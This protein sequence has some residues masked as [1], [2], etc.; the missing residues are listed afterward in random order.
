M[1][2]EARD[3][4][5][6]LRASAERVVA[7]LHLPGESTPGSASRTDK[8]RDRVLALPAAQIAEAAREIQAGFGERHGGLAALLRENATKVLAADQLGDDL[9]V[10]L[11][12]AFT[13]E[14]AIEGAALCNPSVVAHPDQSGL[15]PGQLR[16]VV[17]L[18]SIG[19][20]HVSAISFCTA[21]VGPGRTWAFDRRDLPLVPAATS[22][23]EW[24][25]AHL[26]RSLEYEGRMT[27]L[28]R[29]VIQNLPQRFRS[30]DIERVIGRVPDDFLTH[31]D[32]R[33]RTEE[34]RLVGRSAY[35]A[36]FPAE[37]TLSQRVLLPAADEER[38]GM[39]DARFVRFVE[40]DGSVDYRASYTAYDGHAISSRLLVT[41]DFESFSIRRL[42]GAGTATKGM[43]FFPRRIGGKLFCITRSDGES[44]SLARSDDGME[45]GEETFLRAPTQLWEVIQSGNCGSPIETSRGWLLLTHGVGPMRRYSMGAILL[46]LEDPARV[47]AQLDAPLLEPAGKLQDG[48]VPN[49][50]Y[51]C[52]GIVSDG[53]LWIPH[54]VGDQSIRVVSV[55]LDDLIDAMTP[56]PAILGASARG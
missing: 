4:G 54:G 40:D 50:V 44:L 26:Q 21:I 37:S 39:E 18:R 19:E 29:S 3:A 9:A 27:E 32:A 30:S 13:T 47:V 14:F 12:A 51:S 16:L 53:V 10:V 17:S 35:D 28:A 6:E 23:G 7:N 8:V 1:S 46:D 15:A 33:A 41:R 24:E 43:A 34:I 20:G 38:H 45:W 56:E 11:G 42:S 55:V 36:V 5:V 2:V 25:L 48:Y 52:G 31:Y 49:V 22:E